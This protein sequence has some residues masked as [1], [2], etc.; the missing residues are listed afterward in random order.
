[1]QLNNSTFGLHAK[2][3]EITKLITSTEICNVKTKVNFCLQLTSV[4]SNVTSRLVT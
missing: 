2:Q 3:V 1:M 4:Q